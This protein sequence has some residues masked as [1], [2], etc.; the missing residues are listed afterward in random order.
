MNPYLNNLVDEI[1]IPDIDLIRP[2]LIVSYS[3]RTNRATIITYNENIKTDF[4]NIERVLRSPT[5]TKPILKAY[6]KIM[7]ILNIQKLI[8]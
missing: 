8:F 4:Y 3:H 7:V 5:I 1:G 2:K 6:S